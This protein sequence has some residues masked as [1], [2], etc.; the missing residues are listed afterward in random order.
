MNRR[1]VILFARN[2]ELLKVFEQRQGVIKWYLR[3]INQAITNEIN[4]R[5][6]SERGRNRRK[7]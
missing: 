6:E 7:L 5:R 2:W 4:Q 1:V 3:K